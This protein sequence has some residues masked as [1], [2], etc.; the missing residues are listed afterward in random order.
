MPISS[1]MLMTLSF[2][3][4][5]QPDVLSGTRPSRFLIGLASRSMH[6]KTRVLNV[7]RGD[8]SISSGIDSL[9]DLRSAQEKRKTFYYP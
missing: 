1:D 2:C 4:V 6:K 7:K 3:V 9:C 8:R 5:E